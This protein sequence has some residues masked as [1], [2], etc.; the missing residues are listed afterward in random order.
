MVDARAAERCC[1][2]KGF[3]AL[4]A[5]ARGVLRASARAFLFKLALLRCEGLMRCRC[6]SSAGER[7]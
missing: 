1:A 6:A 4:V 2:A 5:V 3:G 7:S